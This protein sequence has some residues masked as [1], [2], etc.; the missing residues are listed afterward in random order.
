MIS[1]FQPF[2]ETKHIASSN[3]GYYLFSPLLIHPCCDSRRPPLPPSAHPVPAALAAAVPE[4]VAT[5]EEMK[6]ARLDPQWRDYCA[7]MLIPLN[8]CR[9]ANLSMPFR[10]VDE[11]H[12]YEKCQFGQFERRSKE[13]AALQKI[14]RAALRDAEDAAL[15]ARQAKA[16]AKAAE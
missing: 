16:A 14:E 9:R 7:H 3:H 8:K 12:A 5:D 1:L 11:R 15:A 4:M 13:M 2:C 6:A 10:C